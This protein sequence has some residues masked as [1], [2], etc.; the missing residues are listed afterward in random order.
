[1]MDAHVDAAVHERA[2]RSLGRAHDRIHRTAARLLEARGARGR[3]LDAGC[4][5]GDLWRAVSGRFEACT[6][7]D[8]VHFYVFPNDG[9]APAVFVGQG[10]YGAARGDVSQQDPE[11][12]PGQTAH[13]RNAPLQQG[14]SCAH[15]HGQEIARGNLD[16]RLLAV[17][18][19]QQPGNTL[20]LRLDDRAQRS[21]EQA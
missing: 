5:G 9:N 1:M 4:G 2:A 11:H 10:S 20:R 21:G 15:R 8:A 16:E 13:Q 7:V 17:G 14:R 6:G 12:Q 18:R 3:L 19:R